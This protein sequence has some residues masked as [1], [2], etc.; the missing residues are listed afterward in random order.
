MQGCGAHLNKNM[1]NWYDLRH[2]N[3]FTQKIVLYIL[4][5]EVSLKP[6]SSNDDKQRDYILKMFLSFLMSWSIDHLHIYSGP[7][8]LY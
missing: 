7:S 1:T 8:Q 4:Q 5:R 2:L 3:P 6:K